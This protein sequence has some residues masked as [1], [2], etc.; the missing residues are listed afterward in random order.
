[1]YSISVVKVQ[2]YTDD[3]RQNV[4][5]LLSLM[6]AAGFASQWVLP[7]R[8]CPHIDSTWLSSTPQPVWVSF[9]PEWFAPNQIEFSPMLLF[10]SWTKG[11]H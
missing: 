10:E 6:V 11:S 4:K 3:M 5:G 1:M 7:Y 8:V 9:Q 2:P